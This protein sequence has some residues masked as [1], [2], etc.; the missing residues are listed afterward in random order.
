MSEK[1]WRAVLL[2]AECGH[3]LNTAEHV[4][5][6]EKARVALFSGLAGGSCPNGCR[7]T[8]SDM[9]LNTRLEWQQEEAREQSDGK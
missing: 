3:L 9:N 4:P 7:S 8:F 5:E 2:C 6:G 1:L